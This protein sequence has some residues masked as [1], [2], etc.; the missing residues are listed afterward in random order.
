M[1]S[2]GRFTFG[3]PEEVCAPETSPKWSSGGSKVLVYGQTGSYSSP[4]T[5]LMPTLRVLCARLCPIL[6]HGVTPH[7]NTVG[8]V[9]EP[10]KDAVG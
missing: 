9:H 3:V 8:I 7:L 2:F 10:V 4:A 6:T 1:T 5:V